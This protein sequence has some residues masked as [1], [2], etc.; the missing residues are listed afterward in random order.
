LGWN[1]SDKLHDK[2]FNSSHPVTFVPRIPHLGHVADRLTQPQPRPRYRAIG[3]ALS[4]LFALLT[5]VSV[6]HEVLS[7]PLLIQDDARQHVFWMARFANPDLFPNDPIADYF[8]N[9]APIG[10][11]LVYRLAA[12]VGIAPFEFNHIL[13]VLISLA[14]TIVVYGLT[15]ELL[16]LPLTGFLATAIL[17]LSLWMKDDV[18]S[19]TPRAFVYLMLSLFLYGVVR[20]WWG[21]AA[22]AIGLTAS[23]YPQ[24]VIVEGTIA[25]IGAGV[26][27]FPG[28]ARRLGLVR[29]SRGSGVKAPAVDRSSV[30]FWLSLWVVAIVAVLLYALTSGDYG[31]TISLE[32]AR[33]AAEF[34][35]RGRS[36]FFNEDWVRFWLTGE[37]SGFF[38]DRLPLFPW[39]GLLLPLTVQFPRYFPLVAAIDPRSILLRWWL[40]STVSLFGLAHLVLFRLHLP[41]RYAHHNFKLLMAIAAAIAITLWVDGLWRWA[42][43][44]VIKRGRNIVMVNVLCRAGGRLLG[45][46]MILSVAASPLWLTDAFHPAYQTGSAPEV[47]AFLRSTPIDKTI[48]GIDG[49]INNL[50]S[51]SQRS[52]I[53]GFE[54]AIPYQLGYYQPLKQ[55]GVETISTFFS[56]DRQRVADFV[57]R[58][59]LGFWLVRRSSFQADAIRNDKRLGQM[60]KS[61]FQTDPL[62]QAIATAIANLEAGR[63]PVLA[64][65]LDRCAVFSHADFVI[66]DAVCTASPAT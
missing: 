9:V 37:R 51:F 62:V 43:R 34:W 38:P 55:R 14:T 48:A 12:L 60:V 66:L 26:A 32:Q 13:P 15:I 4:L 35:P 57:K 1:D 50:P 3:L 23:F 11:T 52:I 28:L 2:P 22:I 59:N 54:Y 41:S 31:A 56:A 24:Y 64:T 16:P 36:Q 58:Y 63:V 8:Q 17:N 5:G 45:M 27:A 42:K 33:H 40:L 20:R 49:E 6:I 10:Y 65:D 44:G 53:F 47:Y 18:A 46:A 61:D 30:R 7:D 39:L 29:A 25:F 19:G 21:C